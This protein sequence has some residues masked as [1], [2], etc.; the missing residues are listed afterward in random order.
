MVGLFVNFQGSFTSKH[1]INGESKHLCSD[2]LVD[3]AGS[4]ISQE[5]LSDSLTRT[6][7]VTAIDA[8]RHF[9]TG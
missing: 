7:P 2:A 3:R 6:V 9:Q 1:F 5:S 4:V 8:L